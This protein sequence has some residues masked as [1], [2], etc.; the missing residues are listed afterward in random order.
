MSKQ[1]HKNLLDIIKEKKEDFEWYPTTNEIIQAL[2]ISIYDE[3]KKNRFTDFPSVSM[4]DIGAGDGNVFRE[5]D[6]LYKNTQ[7]KKDGLK[8]TSAYAIEK[9]NTLIQAMDP[10]VFVIG[11]DFWNQTLVDKKVDIVFSNPPY[12]SYSQWSE[13]VI[14]ES[15]SKFIYLVIP[16][17]WE[18]DKRITHALDQRDADAEVVGS[19]SFEDSEYRKARAKV[20]LLKISLASKVRH[21]SSTCNIDPFNLWFKETYAFKDEA[22]KEESIQDKAETLNN[23]VPGKSLVERLEELYNQELLHLHA[24]YQSIATLDADLLRE[25]GI[26]KKMMIEGLKLKIENTKN[27]YW[28]ELFNNLDTITSRLTKKS[29]ESLLGTLTEHTSVDFS[30]SN[31]YGIIIWVIKNANKYYDAQ[32]LKLYEDLSKVEN[33]RNYK[34]NK[35]II[36]D[37][38]RFLKEGYSHY[39]LDYRIV[40]TFY[41]LIDTEYAYQAV[42]GLGNAAADFIDD[43]KT[44]ANNLGFSITSSVSD[45]SMQWVS[46]HKNNFMQKTTHG[47]IPLKVGTK[48]NLGK[49]EDVVY[50]DENGCYQYFVGGY[51]THWDSIK[52]EDDIFVEI[53]TFKN[54]NLHAKFNTQFMKKLN[55]EA[56]RLNKWIKT[57]QEAS[58]EFDIS[59]EE[60]NEYFGS[61]YTLTP[62]SVSNL[63]PSLV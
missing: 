44:V 28:Q 51:W 53:K 22:P 5:M 48:T 20:H 32:L 49:I 62:S 63:L 6:H 29:R 40:L 23:L 43:I 39:A 10:D 21:R 59:T 46:Q 35:R 18:E 25:M 61:S 27:V 9:S 3:E 19:F 11:T 57:P 54:G 37:D 56:A 17:R 1:P 47:K 38:W 24:N 55:I 52:T 36:S 4:L 7:D 45:S 14:K 26:S 13:K 8:V 34:S 15:L 12:S 50:Q 31:A 16:E 2:Y 33:I 41:G 42:N 58:D 60:A 30:V